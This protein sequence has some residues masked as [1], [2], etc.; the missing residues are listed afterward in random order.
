MT[1][2]PNMKNAMNMLEVA[3]ANGE[4]AS[5]PHHSDLYSDLLKSA[6]FIVLVFGA[7]TDAQK[8][9]VLEEMDKISVAA[10]AA[11]EATMDTS[12][13]ENARKEQ[14]KMPVIARW[15]ERYNA[16]RQANEK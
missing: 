7:L 16:I 6:I 10:V 14:N 5:P 2:E 8:K 15:K 12:K 3:Y 9:V 4:V 11:V 1:T 13:D